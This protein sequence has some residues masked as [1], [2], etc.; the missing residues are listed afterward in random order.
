MNP[1]TR[2]SIHCYAGDARQVIE[3]LPVHK[4]HECPVTVFSPED[5]PVNIVDMDC[6]FAGKRQSIGPLS[7]ER[8]REHMRILLTYPENFFLMNDADS[9]CLSPQLPQYLYDRP[10]IVWCNYVEDTLEANQPGYAGYSS[11]FPHFAMQ[12]PYFLSRRLME[13]MIAAADRCPPNDVMPW[14][15]HFMMQ[16]VFAAGLTVHRFKDSVAADVDRYPENL[17]PTLDLIRNDGRVFVHSSKSPKTWR[18]MIEARR[19]YLNR[20]T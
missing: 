13:Q 1:D 8:E 3:T 9:F 6:K 7:V 4:R 11:D 19:E 14:I 15:D 17:E 20:E 5:S 12:P 2:V 10:D 16:L 18:P